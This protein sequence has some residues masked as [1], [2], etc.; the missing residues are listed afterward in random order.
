MGMNS[1]TDPIAVK[2]PLVL[3]AA[4]TLAA[5]SGCGSSDGDTPAGTPSGAPQ[6]GTQGIAV[7]ESNP[8]APGG[9]AGG[10]SVAG[11]EEPGP[12]SN[13]PGGDTRAIAGYWDG[14]SLDGASERY[15]VISEDGLWTE[16]FLVE[17]D[18]GGN[19]FGVAGPQT[20]APGD[21]AANAYGLADGRALTATTDAARDALTIDF[22]D[23]EAAAMTWPAVTGRVPADLPVCD[24]P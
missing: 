9:L 5:L 16:Y 24:S 14:S 23:D 22:D 6:D 4:A 21:A 12:I 18:A 13:A 11:P 10:T 17:G 1:H 3:L 20:L 19:C 2:T 15:F 7:G 8:D